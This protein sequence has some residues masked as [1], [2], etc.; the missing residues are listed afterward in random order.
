MA[1]H[2]CDEVGTVGY[3]F[4]GATKVSRDLTAW[5]HRICGD[6]HRENGQRGTSS[7]GWKSRDLFYCSSVLYSSVL[8]FYDVS[9]NVK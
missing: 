3:A 5:D 4:N 7:Q 2:I 8:V 9:D 1:I 6:W